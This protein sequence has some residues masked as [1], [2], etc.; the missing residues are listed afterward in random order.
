MFSEVKGQGFYP[1]SH[2]TPHFKY[3]WV[4]VFFCDRRHSWGIMRC[5]CGWKK[6]KKALLR[7]HVLQPDRF[8]P[9]QWHKGKD[10]CK[11][12]PL[13]LNIITI[14]SVGRQKRNKER[15]TEKRE[16]VYQLREDQSKYSFGLKER[17]T[18]RLKEKKKRNAFK[19]K[20]K[21]DTKNMDIKWLVILHDVVWYCLPYI[22][23]LL[24]K[25]LSLFWK[26]E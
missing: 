24:F 5:A 25:M 8:W 6:Q 14:Q 11:K 13:L 23:I 21:E 12:A 17:K 26:P 3:F 2:Q 4:L 19:L 9:S 16:T 20:V 18:K 15:K 7:V 1:L 22:V 10:E